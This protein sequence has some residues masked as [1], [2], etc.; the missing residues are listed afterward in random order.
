MILHR[1]GE[2]VDYDTVRISPTPEATATHHPL[3]HASLV[4]MVRF[5]LSYFG[6]E[7]VEEHHALAEDGNSYFGLL[8]LKST[9]GDYSDA[10]ALRNNHTK[11]FPAG[12][13]FGSRVF[14]CDNL[15]IC[16][17]TVVARRHTKNLKHQLPSIVAS[18]VE[19]LRAQRER[20][21]GQFLKYQDVAL[22]DDQVDH[23]IMSLYRRGAINVTAI[24]DVLGAY[25]NPP[26]DW[27]GRN[28]W[29]LFNATTYALKGKVAD[30]PRATQ[31]LHDVVDGV[32]ERLN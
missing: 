25:E 8:S 18:I 22:L 32:C 20:Q 12:I 13:S 6:H 23:L 4:D 24:P 11:K 7:V 14:V 30:N 21:H 16:G 27:G 28:A 9:Y 31:T 2:L 15:A 29:R 5:S 3:P 10:I 17:D 26:H 19:P 1:G